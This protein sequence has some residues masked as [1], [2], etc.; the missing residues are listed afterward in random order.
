MKNHK[1]LNRFTVI[2]FS[3][4]I[5]FTFFSQNLYNQTLPKVAVTK[6]RMMEF[7]VTVFLEDGSEFET[8]KREIAIPKQVLEGTH[9]FLLDQTEEGYY[10]RKREIQLGVE[11]EYW[12]E[13]IEGIDKNHRIILGSDR[14]LK[15]GMKV[16]LVE[17]NH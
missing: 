8:T 2:F 4:M 7:P 16:I 14:E 6:T 15:D 3:I 9:L 5:F 17:E 10:V 1:N 11:L 12:V 13:V